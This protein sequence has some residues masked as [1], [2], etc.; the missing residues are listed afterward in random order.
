MPSSINCSPS[1]TREDEIDSVLSSN[2]QD[3]PKELCAAFPGVNSY[4]AEACAAITS[5]S[6]NSRSLIS[7]KLSQSR[8][9]LQQ[10]TNANATA[11]AMPAI[12]GER[13]N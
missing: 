2:A 7:R 3:V 11:S 4:P 13:R 1:S 5:V 8:M 6:G 9:G 12:I 10:S